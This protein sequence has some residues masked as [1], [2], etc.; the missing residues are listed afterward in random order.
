MQNYWQSTLEGVLPGTKTILNE[1]LQSLKLANKTEATIKKY[2]W[3]LER[4]LYN[5]LNLTKC[6]S[7]IHWGNFLK[8]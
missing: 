3:I 2:R 7:F 5:K 6:S 4:F 8:V 1:Y